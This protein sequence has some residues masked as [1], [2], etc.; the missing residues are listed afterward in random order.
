MSLHHPKT[1]KV[2][3][4]FGLGLT[5]GELDFVDVSPDFD[6]PVF[7]D[8]SA[9]SLKEDPVSVSMNDYVVSFF[10]KLLDCIRTGH[11]D[12]AVALCRKLD[13]A[14]DTFLGLSK[15]TPQGR[16]FGQRKSAALIDSIERSTAFR[17]GLLTDLSQSELF[18]PGVGFDLLSDATTNILRY[19][20]SRYTQDVCK[21]YGITTSKVAGGFFWDLSEQKW[22]TDYYEA[23]AIN[24][25]RVML[26]PKFIARRTPVL[27]SQEFYNKQILEFLQTEHLNANSSLVETLRSTRRVVTKKALKANGYGFSK[28]L[29]AK[30]AG[31]NPRLLEEYQRIRGASGPLN[32]DQIEADFDSKAFA[33]ACKV[34]LDQTPPGTATAEAFH[35]LVFGITIFLF[36]P[37]LGCPKKEAKQHDGRKRIDI[38]FANTAN[39]GFFAHCRVAPQTIAVQV[40]FECKNYSTDP[41]NPEFDQ[42]SS[43]FGPSG[44]LGFLICRKIDNR[45]LADKRCSDTFKDGRGS[46]IVLEDNQIRHLLDLKSEGKDDDVLGYLT[47]LHSKILRS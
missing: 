14:E 25:K 12:E 36:Y 44:K 23:P 9:I 45:D 4:Y 37:W 15:G 31:E 41:K 42:L 33:E 43:R 8:P 1:N 27:D 10:E 26:I 21:S 11:R 16:G 7:I 30:I 38:D 2:S 28:D 13:E 22:R 29:I 34:R 6:T 5:Q 46:M 3:N 32:P 24:N 39:E 19:P 35:A 20:L 18:V 40:C 47:S 17:T